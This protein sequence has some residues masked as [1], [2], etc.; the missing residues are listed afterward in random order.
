LG[1]GF[2][3]FSGVCRLLPTRDEYWDSVDDGVFVLTGCA[4]QVRWLEAQIAFAGWAGQLSD[5]RL[6]ELGFGGHDLWTRAETGNAF[7][8]G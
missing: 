5:R 3:W 6:I 4:D 7:P 8:L 2:V 1:F